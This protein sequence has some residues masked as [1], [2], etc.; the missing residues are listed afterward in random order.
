MKTGQVVVQLKND[1]GCQGRTYR[2]GKEYRLG[3][4]KDEIIER[5]RELTEENRK[6]LLHLS[7]EETRNE[8]KQNCPLNGF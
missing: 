4:I 6:H 7:S 5:E 3:E 8:R 1:D 2:E